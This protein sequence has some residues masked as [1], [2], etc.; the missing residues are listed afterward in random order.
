[1]IGIEVGS[2]PSSRVAWW[3]CGVAA[4]A[5]LQRFLVRL[6]NVRGENPFD[7]RPLIKRPALWVVSDELKTGSWT[8]GI[9]NDP[10][11]SA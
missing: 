11:E 6:F 3:R 2:P 10:I 9:C 8:G 5:C 4:P 7:K 1:M